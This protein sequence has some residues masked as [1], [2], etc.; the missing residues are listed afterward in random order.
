MIEVVVVVIASVVVDTKSIIQES[1]ENV[2]LVA[3]ISGKGDLP[4]M[5]NAPCEMRETSRGLPD[6]GESLECE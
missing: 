1:W 3:A 4:R 6:E 2:N 5:Q